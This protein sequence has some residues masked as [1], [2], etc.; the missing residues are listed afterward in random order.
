M[1]VLAPAYFLMRLRRGGPIVPA[2]LW[3]DN[4]DPADPE[5]KLDRGR[6]CPYPR[7]AAAGE[8][9]DPEILIE[10]LGIY[11]RNGDQVALPHQLIERLADAAPPLPSH[12]KYAQPIT[13]DEYRYHLAHL[14]WAERNK[15]DDPKLT[16]RRRVDA[17]QLPLPSF[18]RENSLL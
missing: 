6:L 15:P 12:W 4:A 16:P 18:D 11:P 3:W 9:I 5:N 13:A 14:R 8:E 1:I 7:A 17:A 2:I 10:R